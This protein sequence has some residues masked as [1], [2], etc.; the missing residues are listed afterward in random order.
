MKYRRRQYWMG[1]SIQRS[2]TKAV[3]AGGAFTAM[4]GSVIG[5]FLG[6]S[7]AI[8][9]TGYDDPGIV[10]AWLARPNAT[11]LLLGAM[12][13]AVVIGLLACLGIGY[14]HR[15]AGPMVPIH[16]ALSRI[17]EGDF[18]EPVTIRKDDL[19]Q[20]LVE[21]LNLTFSTIEQRHNSLQKRLRELTHQTGGADSAAATPAHERDQQEQP[22][23]ELHAS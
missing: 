18:S 11:A 14:S 15:I 20:D 22:S 2:F 4:L 19:L 17:R 1:S 10:I 6:A 23:E 5:F 3:V 13:S 21:D 12:V 7:G 8:R 16:R 9:A